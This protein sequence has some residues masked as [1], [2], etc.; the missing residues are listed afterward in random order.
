MRRS[1]ILVEFRDADHHFV[2]Q[3]LPQSSTVTLLFNAVST[4]SIVVR[5]S[6]P[7]VSEIMQGGLRAVVWMVVVDGN[8]LEKTRL[9]EG[10][11]G[12]PSGD[13]P[14]GTVTI[15][16][17]D[18]LWLLSKT[19]AW[20]NPGKAVSAQT[21]E[22]AVYTGPSDT[23]AL[24]VISANVTR[25]GLPWDIATPTGVGSSG[26]T[27]VRMDPVLGQ[28][29]DALT[30]DRILLTVARDDASARWKVAVSQGDEYTR[31][32]TPSSG[33]VGSWHWT[34]QEAALTRVVVG[35]AGDGPDREF[36]TVVDSALEAAL[37]VV[38]EGFVD[39][40]DA[41]S[42]EDLTPYGEAA[43][44]DAASKAGM[45]ATLRET[46]WFRFPSAY[47]VGTR[48]HL[49]FDALEFT[50]VVSQV[51]IIQTTNDGFVVVPTVGFA[52]SDPTT[53]QVRFVSNVA[54]S[55]RKLERR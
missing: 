29:V 42:G 6:D 35:G 17:K 32:L 7:V 12:D 40:S 36:A 10:R 46:A 39:A 11:V 37:G 48:L 52:D 9:M 15:P 31:P 47:T 50:D 45:T 41:E 24:N 1:R 55:V 5:D 51:Q 4:A 13:G 14:F 16:V 27:Q 21:D 18:D 2:R 44:A 53:R 30:A 23:R 3:V 33:V 49:K 25:L 34:R 8:S 19:L 26:S 28:I 20:P 38:L 43:L 22:V 54:A